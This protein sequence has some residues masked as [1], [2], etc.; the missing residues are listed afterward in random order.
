MIIHDYLTTVSCDRCSR[1][2]SVQKNYGVKRMRK[3]A[4]ACGWRVVKGKDV[5]DICLTKEKEKGHDE[6]QGNP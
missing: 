6:H 4:S 2:L 1:E 3:I 5:C